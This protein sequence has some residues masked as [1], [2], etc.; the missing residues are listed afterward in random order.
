LIKNLNTKQIIFSVFFF[1]FQNKVFSSYI[2]EQLCNLHLPHASSKFYFPD[3]SE[4]SLKTPSSYFLFKMKWQQ[5]INK[6]FFKFFE[7]LQN[8]LNISIEQIWDLCTDEE[9][10]QDFKQYLNQQLTLI[11]NDPK[12]VTE[13]KLNPYLRNTLQKGIE[14]FIPQKNITL[15]TNPNIYN[16]VDIFFD[17]TNDMYVICFNAHLYNLELIRNI[18]NNI[19][20]KNSYYFYYKILNDEDNYILYSEFINSGFIIASSYMHHQLSLIL[21]ILTNYK[22]SGKMAHD[23]TIL[24]LKRLMSFQTDIEIILQSN[25]PLET[26]Y[27]YKKIDPFKKHTDIWELMINDISNMYSTESL[28]KFRKIDQATQK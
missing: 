18:N 21:H 19:H 25:N 13:K 14:K 3:K 23:D 4:I 27:F 7:Q 6:A 20:K 11:L 9:I 15:I 1:L 8:D 2:Q 24:F 10:I 28:T 16:L 26:A 5:K 17:T 12:T 22:F